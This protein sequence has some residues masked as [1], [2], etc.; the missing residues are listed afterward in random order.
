[1]ENFRYQGPTVY[2]LMVMGLRAKC[3]FDASDV[4]NRVANV[5]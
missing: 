2:S 5:V 4:R 3:R 1:M